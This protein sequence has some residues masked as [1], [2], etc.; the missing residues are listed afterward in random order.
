[1][2]FTGDKTM[3]IIR[4]EGR[5]LRLD[6]HHTFVLERGQF[7]IRVFVNDRW[8]MPPRPFPP[9]FDQ[10]QAEFDTVESAAK[11]IQLVYNLQVFVWV[12]EEGDVL[13]IENPKEY[14]RHVKGLL[15]IARRPQRAPT[16]RSPPRAVRL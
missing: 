9:G 5:A 14:I 7:G 16:R 8:W 13:E 6:D 12:D 15:G 1:M 10:E 3:T 4:F 2:P 11:A